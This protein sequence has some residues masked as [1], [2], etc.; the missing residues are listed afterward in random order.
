M[1]NLETLS[2]DQS[3]PPRAAKRIQQRT[4]AFVAAIAIVASVFAGC[5]DD[6][7][8][9]ETAA[10]SPNATP[11]PSSSSTEAGT[12]TRP[13]STSP[14][15]HLTDYD[16]ETTWEQDV[17]ERKVGRY[18]ENVWHDPAAVDSLLVID[19]QA[20]DNALS[21]L[22]AAELARVQTGWLSKYHE[23]SFKKVK[24]GGHTA[25]R[26]T[27]SVADKGHI[28]YFFAKCGTSIALH[29]STAL[30]TFKDFADYYRVAASRVKIACGE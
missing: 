18:L 4:V 29:G 11:P 30:I 21:P 3:F 13:S 22:A 25:V 9:T 6:G 14:F 17:S 23:R 19:S 28:E 27:F 8:S 15:H 26:W 16:V 2:D 5:G 20:S 24:V 1:T 12:V 7:S 10:V